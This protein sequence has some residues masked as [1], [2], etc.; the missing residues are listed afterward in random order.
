MVGP[1]SLDVHFWLLANNHGKSMK[2]S[3]LLLRRRRIILINRLLFHLIL[4]LISLWELIY[5]GGY[6][7]KFF[8]DDLTSCFHPRLDVWRQLSNDIPL[9][10]LQKYLCVK[11]L[12]KI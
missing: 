4:L 12:P 8:E 1:G 11:V 3:Q 10:T 6:A 2:L 5:I 9:S 7:L